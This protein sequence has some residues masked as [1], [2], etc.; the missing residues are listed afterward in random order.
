[1]KKRVKA[2][3]EIP[4]WLDRLTTDGVPD[5]NAILYGKVSYLFRA[6]QLRCDGLAAI[7]V[8]IFEGEK[9][10]EWP[11]PASLSELIWKWESSM[12]LAG[13]AYGEIVRNEYGYQK[14]VAY[15]NPYDMSV[16]YWNGITEI[17]QGSTGA[18]WHNDDRTGEYQIVYMPEFDPL[19]DV[20]PGIGSGKASN[21]ASKLLF[22]LSKFPEMYFEG[23]AM[24]VTLLGIDTSDDNEIKRVESWFKR[25]ATSIKNAFR[26]LGI[27]ADSIKPTTLTPPLK[28]LVM[29]EITDNA[30]E[31][32]S[33]AF[34][35]PKT[36]LDS[37]AANYATAKEDRKSFYMETLEP[38]SK[39]IAAALNTQLLNKEGLRIEFSVKEMEIF[40]EDENDRADRFERYA[41][42]LPVELALRLAG[43]ELTDEEQA[44]LNVGIAEPGANGT[45]DVLSQELG[46][47]MRMVEKRV[48][49][50]KAIRDFETDI[51]PA[52]L[53]GAISG[54]LDTV[55][56]VED[57]KMIFENA[58]AWETYP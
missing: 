11:Y 14:N 20:L 50:G 17:R 39:K 1:M 41:N 52:G 33:T 54:A 12:L 48:R 26:V 28:D 29:G 38:R 22:A 37:E 2:I 6:V 23:G 40:Q 3:T 51:I 46:R 45:P 35:I 9:E 42:R 7:P 10:T 58:R 25:S 5:S 36:L 8:K 32:I 31:D 43:I 56:T 44:L 16:N 27:R 13:A 53:Y 24:P 55:K 18:V 34:G 47:W 15:R 21:V 19:Q 49:D 4:G 57:V 30:K